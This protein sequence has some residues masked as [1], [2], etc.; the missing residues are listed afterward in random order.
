MRQERQV[1][2]I[3][4]IIYWYLPCQFFILNIS[5]YKYQHRLFYQV[6]LTQLLL[7]IYVTMQLI[8]SQP[9]LNSVFL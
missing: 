5:R 6:L 2:N 3:A 4:L 1:M 9:I 8:I 7:K